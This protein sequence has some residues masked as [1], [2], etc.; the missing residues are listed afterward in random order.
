VVYVDLE[1][2]AGPSGNG[3]SWAGAF[4]SVQDG[5]DLAADPGMVQLGCEVWVSEGT[6]HIFVAAVSDAV[7][8]RD[9]VPVYGGF[10]GVET[11]RDQRDWQTHSTVLDGRHPSVPSARVNHV[12]TANNVTGAVLDG[13]VVSYGQAATDGGGMYVVQSAVT[14]SNCRFDHNAAGTSGGGMYLQ[15][16][17]DQVVVQDTTFAQ[18]SATDGG[19]V[20]IV[21]GEPTIRRCTF[22]QNSAADYGG[23]LDCFFCLSPIRRCR[24]EANT[25]DYGGGLAGGNATMNVVTCVFFDNQAVRG[26]GVNFNTGGTHALRNCTFYGNTATGE[27][28]G[29]YMNSTTVTVVNSILWADSP[30]EISCDA[31]TQDFSYCD[32]QGGWAGTAILNAS[33]VFTDAAA[34]DFHLQSGSP[35]IDAGDGDSAPLVD[36]QGLSR[37]DDPLTTDTGTGTPTYTDLGAYEYQP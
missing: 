20:S 34:G 3:G 7:N 32:I 15:D 13:F 30:E 28:G 5:I 16:C 18:N 10:S 4:T 27:G 33:P 25:A 1:S 22:F 19:G 21:R 9:D 24:F 36:F 23:G 2:P 14:V 17:S 12:V 11:A 29:I 37:A 26:G 6:Y 31:C 35:C 8:L